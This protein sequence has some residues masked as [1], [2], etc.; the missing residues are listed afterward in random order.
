LQNKEEKSDHPQATRDANGYPLRGYDIPGPPPP[1][2]WVKREDVERGRP[3][4]DYKKQLLQEIQQLKSR[5][6]VLVTPAPPPPKNSDS[7]PN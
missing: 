3:L 1:S 2:P 6:E 5:E 7:V 4:A